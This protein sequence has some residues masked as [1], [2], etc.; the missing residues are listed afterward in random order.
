ML[1][2]IVPCGGDDDS[3][4]EKWTSLLQLVYVLQRPENWYEAVVLDC[5]AC[6][7]Q[8]RI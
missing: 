1:R 6:H 2:R 5:E 7:N 4:E 3:P 8:L